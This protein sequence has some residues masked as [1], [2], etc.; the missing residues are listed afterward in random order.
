LD[1]EGLFGGRSTLSRSSSGKKENVKNRKLRLHRKSY[2]VELIVMR[3]SNAN[4]CVSTLHVFLMLLAANEMRR[5][6]LALRENL[7]VVDFHRVLGSL[8][9]AP[10]ENVTSAVIDVRSTDAG[11]VAIINFLLEH[12]Q[13]LK[14]IAIKHRD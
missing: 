5:V 14:A 9:V 8:R 3:V 11:K 4:V 12:Q 1:F 6:A 7:N 10:S 2:D 13:R